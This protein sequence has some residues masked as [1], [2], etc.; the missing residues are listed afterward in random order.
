VNDDQQQRLDAASA[1]ERVGLWEEASR[2]LDAV[3]RSALEQQDFS[4][5]MEAL[6]RLAYCHSRAG[7]FA[8]AQHEFARVL[9]L[10]E[11]HNV[12]SMRG[13]ALNGMGDLAR[14]S[15]NMG[16]AERLF[17]RAYRCGEESG[18]PVLLGN[19]AQNLGILANIRGDLQGARDYYLN[20]LE[21]IRRGGTE[22]QRVTVLNNLGMLHVD[23]GEL[24]QAGRLFDEALEICQ[25]LGDVVRAG[26]IHVNRAELYVAAG[27]LLRA[28]ES[29]D[30]GFEIFSQTGDNLNQAEALRFYGVI[31]R[32]SGKPHLAAI[33][34]QRAA[35]IAAQRDPLLEAE[36]QR[37]LALVLRELGRNRDAL[38]ALNRSHTLF[39]GL[40]AQTDTADIQG[41]IDQLETDF[42]VL[43]QQWGESIE[44]KDRYT[45]G[46]CLRVADYACRLAEKVGIAPHEMVWFRMGAFLHDLGKIEVP[47]EVLN[48]P[49][50]LTDEERAVME[51]HPVT[52]EAMLG[53]VD[54]PWDIRPMVRSHHERWD[55]GGYP[56]RLVG[57]AI[58]FSARILRV[59]DVFD[60][61]TTARSYRRPLTPAEAMAIMVED[62]GSF[63]AQI[64]A[65]FQELFPEL[66]VTAEQASS[67]YP[68]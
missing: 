7:E 25:R 46:H 68:D 26:I 45:V 20:G 12:P 5:S 23:L 43:V 39:T 15:G 55:G 44:A 54:F 32:K 48:K 6:A 33:H 62:Q 56:D 60:A 42:L 29:C 4:T 34:L 67:I 51:R 47:E 61:L 21:H 59:A 31:Y 9:E 53:S 66:S 63:D 13:R 3:Y 27:D 14:L 10:A 2:S 11:A 30:E 52:G 19:A 18:D 58:P 49:G 24:D 65:A 50:R 36:A 35:D 41:R 38:A 28:R 16:E 8:T 22:S 40:Q 1:L 17:H 57:E 64:F 37:E